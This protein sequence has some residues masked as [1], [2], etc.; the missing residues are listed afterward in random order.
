MKKKSFLSNNIDTIRLLSFFVL[1]IVSCLSLL[2]TKEF[3]FEYF[4]NQLT[5]PRLH[6]PNDYEPSMIEIKYND[7]SNDEFDSFES[8]FYT[9]VYNQ[10]V[11]RDAII[12][13]NKIELTATNTTINDLIGPYQTNIVSQFLYTESD[14]KDSEDQKHILR[15]GRYA[16]YLPISASTNGAN[17]FIY[18]SDTTADYW[19]EKIGVS[20]LKIL[21]T[22]FKSTRYSK[23]ISYL[24]KNNCYFSYE[25]VTPFTFRVSNV[26]YTNYGYSPRTNL[27]HGEF[28]LSHALCS[29][30]ALK[31]FDYH[32]ELETHIDTF[33]NKQI[34]Q[35][36][37]SV[38][39]NKVSISFY[40][41]SYNGTNQLIYSDYLTNAYIMIQNADDFSY[42]YILV[43]LFFALN[44]FL[45]IFYKRYGIINLKKTILLILIP[46]VLYGLVSTYV[47]LF[48]G[49]GLILLLNVFMFAL[50][51]G[52]GMIGN[53][54]RNGKNDI[55]KKYQNV[56]F[57]EI[58][59]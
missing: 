52:R 9:Y 39:K 15:H 41:P 42:G 43:F 5:E 17:E 19:I 40:V 21:D 22:D 11:D 24:D 12:T 26:Y 14:T 31:L 20:A 33:G 38:Y 37:E 55:S 7:F 47:Y 25:K 3:A 53:V 6:K 8:L 50:I 4:C 58:D 54:L 34:L 32:Y 57:Y 44:V 28:A 51:Y 59:I 23:L 48:S 10:S 56:V 49:F 2:P 35:L 27:I 16:L 18:I 13:D 1:V 36:V 29:K 46:I 30:Q 45:Q